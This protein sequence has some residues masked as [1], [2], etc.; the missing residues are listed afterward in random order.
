M[1]IVN[2]ERL[3]V[4]L[5]VGLAATMVFFITLFTKYEMQLVCAILMIFFFDLPR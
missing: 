1:L 2:R 4:L 5:V 3:Y